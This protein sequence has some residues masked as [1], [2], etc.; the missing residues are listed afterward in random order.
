M[1][2]RGEILDDSSAEALSKPL[3][4][5]Q[6]VDAEAAGSLATLAR[7]A[8]LAALAGGTRPLLVNAGAVLERRGNKKKRIEAAE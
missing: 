1:L 6:P 4:S 8:T 3:T 2:D 5:A 7:A